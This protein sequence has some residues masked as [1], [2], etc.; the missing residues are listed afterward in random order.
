[1][2][3][4]HVVVIFGVNVGDV[5]DIFEAMLT[6]IKELEDE[7]A[8]QLYTRDCKALAASVTRYPGRTGKASPSLNTIFSH[9]AVLLGGGADSQ[10]KA[11]W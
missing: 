8:V 6:M 3:A 1:M 9:T 7:T 2:A 10:S 5:S 11:H 4:D